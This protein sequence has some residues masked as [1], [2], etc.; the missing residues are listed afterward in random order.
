M[1]GQREVTEKLNARTRQNISKVYLWVFQLTTDI[2]Q[3]CSGDDI[4]SSRCGMCVYNT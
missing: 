1:F 3:I 2:F 4:L